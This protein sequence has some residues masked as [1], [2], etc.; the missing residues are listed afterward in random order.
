MF[1]QAGLSRLSVLAEGNYEQIRSVNNITPNPGTPETEDINAWDL[2][3]TISGRTPPGSA[4]VNL[5]TFVPQLFPMDYIIAN[6]GSLSWRVDTPGKVELPVAADREVQFSNTGEITFSGAGNNPELVY[7]TNP[8]QVIT[9]GGKNY[10]ILVN[11]DNTVRRVRELASDGRST[12]AVTAVVS[13]GTYKL[14]T[15]TLRYDFTGQAQEPAPGWP[16]TGAINSSFDITL[17]SVLRWQLV[18][19]S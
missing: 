16:E 15:P 7:A 6:R 14:T 17:G 3:A 10:V 5:A 2:T 8:G 9:V 13:K 12:T 1:F 18:I 4:T 19:P 11:E